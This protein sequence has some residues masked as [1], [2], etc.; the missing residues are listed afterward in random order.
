VD[1]EAKPGPS[2]TRNST[3]LAT[4]TRRCREQRKC[5]RS[6]RITAS[7]I[8]TDWRRDCR[9]LLEMLW[10]C[11]DSTPF[12]LALIPH[13]FLCSWNERCAISCPCHI[14]FFYS[15]VQNYKCQYSLVSFCPCRM[16][17]DQ[18]EHSD[19]YQVIDTP[20]D[21]RT[22]KEDLLGGNY[23]S[24][25]EFCKDMRLIFINS[26]NYNTNQRSRVSPYSSVCKLS[27]REFYVG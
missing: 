9:D 21:L 4:S 5:R 11:E 3:N 14:F 10:S 24:P 12:R 8:S 22:V 26:K 19:Y 7:A 23:Q 16:P 20:M 27:C 15:T 18:L 2:S 13:K 17:V 25:L 1:V 6:R